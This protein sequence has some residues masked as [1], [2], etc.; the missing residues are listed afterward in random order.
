MDNHCRL[1]E[2]R[3]VERKTK[4]KQKRLQGATDPGKALPQKRVRTQDDKT[5][6]KAQTQQVL[7][8]IA[9]ARATQGATNKLIVIEPHHENYEAVAMDT[10][11]N[12][13]LRGIC[14]RKVS[15][16]F[17][18]NRPGACRG[19]SVEC[20]RIDP[21]SASL[22]LACSNEDCPQCKVTVSRLCCDTCNPG[23]FILP[24]PATTALRQS[25]APNRFKLNKSCKMSEADKSLTS[26][27]REWRE[28]QLVHIS[29]PA[30]D[31]MYR[32][33]LIMTDNILE[34]IVG[35]AHHNQ[36][37]DLVSIKAQVNW[38]YNDL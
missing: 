18:R 33:Q 2:Q 29:I 6:K 8:D 9:P 15:E 10:Y 38:R 28:A 16:E 27:L 25:R 20:S 7:P 14:R 23:S 13:S 19:L 32:S 31:D 24:V 30:G 36:L 37:A 22:S 4:S 5:W 35:L 21:R 11:I 34:R 26:A 17:F 3:A 1:A 12:A